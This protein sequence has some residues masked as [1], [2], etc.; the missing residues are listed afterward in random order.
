MSGFVRWSD[1][2]IDKG[3]GMDRHKHCYTAEVQLRKRR[4]WQEAAKRV[5]FHSATESL[6]DTELWLRQRNR[7]LHHMNE[8]SL[9]RCWCI[10]PSCCNSVSQFVAIGIFNCCLPS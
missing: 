6:R 1:F 3:E 5:R 10:L 9:N 7:I 4:A 2:E 8:T